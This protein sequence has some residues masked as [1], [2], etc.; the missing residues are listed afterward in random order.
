MS[1]RDNLRNFFIRRKETQNEP[2]PTGYEAYGVSGFD[3]SFVNK[4][5]EYLQQL[6]GW[7]A[8][9]ITAIADEFATIQIRLYQ[10]TNKGIEEIEEH[11]ILNLLY[12]V[13]SFTTKFDHFWLTQAYLD[14]TGESPWLLERDGKKITNIYFLKPDKLTPK[15]GDNKLINSYEYDIGMGKKIPLSLD[16]VLFLRYPNPNK[17]FR[18]IGT[19]EMAAKTV[20]IDSYSE[21]WNKNFYINSARPDAIVTVGKS[22]LTKE[23]KAKLKKSIEETYTG[24]EKAHKTMVLFGDMK[25]EKSSFSVK[26]MDFLEQQ[27][28]SRD[29]IM[30]VFRVPKAIIAQTEGVNYAS[31]KAAQYIFARWTIKPR[32]ERLVQQ[33]NEFL[34]PMF[35]GTENMFLDYDNPVQEDKESQARIFQTAINSGYMTINEVRNELGFPE[36]E[37]GDMIYLQGFPTP[38]D[39]AGEGSPFPIGLSYKKGLGKKLKFSRDRIHELKARGKRYFKVQNEITKMK[40]EIKD[41]IWGEYKNTLRK[42]KTKEI[43]VTG[44]R[45]LKAEEVTKFWNAKNQLFKKY[46]KDVTEKMAELFKNQKR[47]TLAKYSKLNNKGLLKTKGVDDIYNSIKLD[48]ENEIGKTLDLTLPLLK[49]LFKEA[50]DETY[51]LLELDKQFNVDREEIKKLLR[52]KGRIFSKIVTETTNEEIKNQLTEGL[53]KG[54]SVEEISKRL[55]SVFEGAEQVRADKIARTET[56]RYNTSATEQAFQDSEIVE[57]KM[58]VTDP[59]PCE[60]CQTLAGKTASLGE[61]FVNKG[62]QIKDRVFDYEDLPAPP[63]HPNCQCDLI[64]VFKKSKE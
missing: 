22:N 29:K 45:V 18:G 3:D 49:K 61:T 56:L 37:G 28:F 21:D 4:N 55:R 41:A 24:T 15:T 17:P 36:I 14:L 10:Y 53:G 33:L 12:K 30:G 50:G 60:Y 43:A 54:E 52:E 51:K 5:T 40:K 44:Q 48:I 42:K 39:K 64:P 11:D 35:P 6:K 7:V 58:W 46:L 57:G 47:R 25:F 2:K 13:N 32:M 8:S 62:D 1:L 16:E 38:L 9:C 19:L 34:L 63:L 20:A 27:R 23:E 26:D 31:A 59:N